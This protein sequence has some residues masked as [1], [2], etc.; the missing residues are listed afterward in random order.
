MFANSNSCFIAQMELL[1]TFIKLTPEEREME[2]RRKTFEDLRAVEMERRERDMKKLKK[3]R[4]EREKYLEEKRIHEAEQRAEEDGKARELRTLLK[5]ELEQLEQE[6]LLWKKEMK[7]EEQQERQE[8][9]G[10]CRLLK[11]G[12][13][14]RCDLLTSAL[15]TPK[16]QEKKKTLMN[17]WVGEPKT[18][19]AKP[20]PL[21]STNLL[22]AAQETPKSEGFYHLF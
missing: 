22:Y 19:R 7:V 11:V 10:P 17:I 1:K 14:T 12:D 3:E 8:R 6:R 21:E 15:K 16:H 18:A 13:R 5:A 2:I 20:H 9:T 4:E